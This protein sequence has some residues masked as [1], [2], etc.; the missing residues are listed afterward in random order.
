[1]RGC[2]YRMNVSRIALLFPLLA[3]SLFARAECPAF[4]TQPPYPSG[5]ASPIELLTSDFNRDGRMDVATLGQSSISFEL[6]RGDGTFIAPGPTYPTGNGAW[7]MAAGDLN[8]DGIDDV[9]VASITAASLSVFLSK[10][11]GTATSFVVPVAAQPI[12]LAIAEVTSDGNPDLIVGSLAG[13]LVVYAGDGKGNLASQS[14]RAIENF[15]TSLAFVTRDFN[16]DGKI[17]IVA[18]LAEI[19]TL[20]TFYG[21]GDGTF[22]TGPA[23]ST[24]ATGGTRTLVL[25]DF[26][27]DGKTDVAHGTAYNYRVEIFHGNGDGS[28]RR[29]GSFDAGDVSWSMLATDL[30]NDG[31]LDLV[32]TMTYTSGVRVLIGTG[33]GKFAAPLVLQNPLFTPGV[34]AGDFDRDGKV[35]I[36]SADYSSSTLSVLK[37]TGDC[38]AP[39]SSKR[40]SARH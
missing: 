38:G 5:A 13:G 21:R 14:I 27:R 4:A 32:A 30:T 20:G 7:K 36:V 19:A 11:D 16:G 3:F 28:F 25:A 24:T 26:D 34:T 22:S 33:G 17:D 12:S 40:R 9:V 15:N 29:G 23:I 18:S 39:A 1:M 31:N 10:G 6:G 2:C 35:D 37:N 8:L